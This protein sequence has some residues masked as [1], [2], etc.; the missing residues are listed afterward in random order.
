MRLLNSFPENT[1]SRNLFPATCAAKRCRAAPRRIAANIAKL[2]ELLRNLRSWRQASLLLYLFSSGSA[3]CSNCSDATR[4]PSTA[5]VDSDQQ[6]LIQPQVGVHIQQVPQPQP[7]QPPQPQ[8]KQ[9]LKNAHLQ[10]T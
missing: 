2:P 4:A 8:P 5:G 7:P 9:R 1:T 6:V 10:C 3:V